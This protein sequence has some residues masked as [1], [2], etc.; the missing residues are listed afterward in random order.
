MVVVNRIVIVPRG[1]LTERV[2]VYFAARVFATEA[3]LKLAMIWDHPIEFS[4]LF[5]DNAK[6]V[7]HTTLQNLKYQ[8]YVYVPSVSAQTL[9][10]MATYDA[11]VDC[12]IVLETSQMLCPPKMS[13]SEF[14]HKLSTLI[15][16]TISNNMAG[17]MQGIVNTLDFPMG[18]FI[19][20]CGFPL[21][22]SKPAP[23]PELSVD[24]LDGLPREMRELIE[25]FAYG[26][27]TV[28]I[29]DDPKYARMAILSSLTRMR[30]VIFRF[31]DPIDTTISTH[32][33][34]SIVQPVHEGIVRVLHPNI[35]DII[36]F[37]Y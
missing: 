33:M 20:R 12:A 6:E 24:A 28:I 16:Y 14:A 37:M 32:N 23:F 25:T 29:C 1:T 7:V 36:S 19:G 9:L 10:E 4:N 5:I 11:N 35:V 27:A 30:P 31:D 8:N 2:F 13:Y 17:S 21:P 15:Q 22:N 3:G 18:K 26:K 34:G